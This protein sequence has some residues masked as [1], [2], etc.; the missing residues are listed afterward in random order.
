M[1]TPHLGVACKKSVIERVWKAI[2]QQLH[3]TCLNKFRTP[4][5]L[6][7][8]LFSTWAMVEGDFN[9][10]SKEFHGRVFS[11]SPQEVQKATDAI[12]DQKYRMICI[13]DSELISDEDYEGLKCAIKEAY[14]KVLPEKSQYE[15]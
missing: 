3:K 4:T 6:I 9:P 8:Q 2:P 5:D 10:V 13:N 15:K 14:E 7:Y 11:G 1:L 12:V